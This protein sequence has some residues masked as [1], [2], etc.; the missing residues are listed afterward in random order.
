M[1]QDHCFTRN[2]RRALTRL[3]LLLTA[4]LL[5][6]GCCACRGPGSD[7]SP[8]VPNT[9]APA[10]HDGLFVS[11][12]GSLRFNGDGESVVIDFDAYLAEL[13]GLPEGEQQ[14]TYDFLSGDLPPHGSVPVRY[15][16][17]HELRLTVGEQSV[18][19]D[20]AIASADGKTSQAGINTVTPERIP[21]KFSGENGYFT[22]Y[23]EKTDE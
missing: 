6:W 13:T 9:P 23:F 11:E 1:K 19:L 15:D 14:A 7:N 8:Y 16:A 17:A 21:M 22:I 5:I 3:C 12:H 18:V 10:N 20:M 2:G 4:A